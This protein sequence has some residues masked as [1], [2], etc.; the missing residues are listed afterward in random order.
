MSVTQTRPTIT[1]E[2]W[3]RRAKMIGETAEA[4]SLEADK[5]G[6]FSD[7]VAKAIEEAEI[8]KLMRSPRY[9]GYSMD[10]DLGLYVEVVRTVGFYSIPAAWL[11]YFY[12]I[13]DVW[14]HY[15]PPEGR[16]EVL[17][18]GGL[19]ADVLAPVGRAKKDGDGFRVTGKWNF[20]SG[21]L[22]SEWTG[23][24]ALVELEEGQGEEV[25]L[26]AAHES[27]F[28]IIKNWDTLGLRPTGSNGVSLD[29]VYIP[30]SR[31]LP[32]KY[33]MK[34]GEPMGGDYDKNDPILRM[35]FI[36]FF[37]LGFLPVAMGGVDRMMSLFH[38][39]T[40]NR[41]RVF[42]QGVKEKESPSS[43]RLYAIMQTELSSLEG[44]TD[45]YVKKLKAY[46]KEGKTAISDK[47]REEFFAL[48][49][50]VARKACNMIVEI[51]LNLGGTSIYKGDPVERFTRDILAFAAHPN[52]SFEDSMAAFGRTNFGLP[53]D[54]VW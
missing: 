15:L 53:G 34:L 5:N 25:C 33:L 39:K 17:G 23:L 37:L 38:E 27:E 10:L 30:R 45:I 2:E 40:S 21:I 18:T 41:V 24:G 11:T 32:T 19:L 54:P 48:R 14:A 4:E 16:D 6:Q 43:Q 46:E 26:V 31:I 52:H 51:M 22:W 9:G 20:C 36:P 42:K 28:N 50:Q 29:N 7:K 1:R 44:L 49:G 35:P 13:H 47:E 3:I 8:H 12:S